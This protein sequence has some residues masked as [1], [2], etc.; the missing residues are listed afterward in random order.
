MS[1][2]LE[3]KILNFVITI[4]VVYWVIVIFFEQEIIHYYYSIKNS[5]HI[6]LSNNLKFNN[7]I[8]SVVDKHKNH[9]LLKLRAYSLDE[10]P[11]GFIYL[12]DDISVYS[13][14]LDISNIIV[15]SKDCFA[16][17]L[18]SDYFGSYSFLVQHKKSN[19]TFM[20]VNV[21]EQE[22]IDLLCTK[23]ILVGKTY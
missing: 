11:I 15:N 22:L 21:L 3:R 16:L 6:F 1:N 17:R 5:E 4:S 12:N 10:L 20:T 9:Y 13:N 18:E 14:E 2:K 23:A 7:E 19:Y 8:I